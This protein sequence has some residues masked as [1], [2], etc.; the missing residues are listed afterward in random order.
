MTSAIP[1]PTTLLRRCIETN[2]DD[3]PILPA[4]TGSRELRMSSPI[5][6][7][8]RCDIASRLLGMTARGR[9]P[10]QES[11]VTN[12]GRVATARCHSAIARWCASSGHHP[13]IMWVEPVGS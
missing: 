9:G 7:R 5:L 13:A 12:A 4:T 10:T 11:E 8:R 2:T 1:I 3:G 6:V